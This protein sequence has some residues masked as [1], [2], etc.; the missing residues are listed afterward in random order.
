LAAVVSLLYHRLFLIGCRRVTGE[1]QS[2]SD[3]GRVAGRSRRHIS[4]RVSERDGVWGVHE[5]SLY[6]W[7]TWWVERRSRSLGLTVFTVSF[8]SLQRD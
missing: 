1:R 2:G 4:S 8:T 5:G 6:D 3:P 7:C